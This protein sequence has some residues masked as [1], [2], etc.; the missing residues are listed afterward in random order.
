MNTKPRRDEPSTTDRQASDGGLDARDLEA[1]R[2]AVRDLPPAIDALRLEA[3]QQRVLAQ[4][5]Q[6]VGAQ[7]SAT[8][9]ALDAVAPAS[10]G[11]QGATLHHGRDPRSGR[12]RWVWFGLAALLLASA[13]VLT[14]WP[15]P[16]DPVLDELMRIDVLSQMSAGV[17]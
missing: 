5:S 4:W 11:P 15:Q 8:Q 14:L 13:A 6:A 17:M 12:P 16:P 2:Q 9:S 7:T 3:L 1:L 10:R